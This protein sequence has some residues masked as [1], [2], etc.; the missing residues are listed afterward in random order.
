MD[1]VTS[2]ARFLQTQY[3]IVPGQ[4][5]GR[6]RDLDL[7]AFWDR[8]HCNEKLALLSSSNNKV[9]VHGYLGMWNQITQTTLE[10]CSAFDYVIYSFWQIGSNGQIINRVESDEKKLASAMN[11]RVLAGVGGWGAETDWASA[12]GT[13]DKRATV[14]RALGASVQLAGWSGIDLD[15]EYPDTEAELL[16][17][18]AFIKQYREYWPRQK[19]GVALAAFVDEKLRAKWASDIAPYVDWFHVMTY[20]FTGAWDQ[21]INYN[22]SLSRGR[23]AIENWEASG[24][25]KSKLMLGSAWYGRAATVQ[26]GS[27]VRPGGVASNWEELSFADIVKDTRFKESVHVDGTIWAWDS[28]GRK[29]VSYE[30]VDCVREKLEA[31]RQD[32]LAGVFCW[33]IG[34]DNGSL[35]TVM[36]Q[37]WLG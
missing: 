24:I 32:N 33:E 12:L 16:A 4:T 26:S 1:D 37:A 27:L 23:A 21:T 31:A 10:K 35:S 20:D 22:S 36:R 13:V 14:A 18:A 30:N 9:P 28:N 17:L 11:G 25:P 19:I 15:W 8:N 2:V 5:W 3:G 29:V 7:R 6:L 34:Q